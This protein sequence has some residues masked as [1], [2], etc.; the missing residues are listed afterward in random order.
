[1]NLGPPLETGPDLSNKRLGW[2]MLDNDW[3]SVPRTS[4][5]WKNDGNAHFKNKASHFKIK[6]IRR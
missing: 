4:G 2:G 1:M 5:D 3:I 6:K